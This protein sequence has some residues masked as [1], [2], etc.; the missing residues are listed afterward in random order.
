[1]T[2]EWLGPGLQAVA[3]V[4]TLVAAIAA[5][6]AAATANRLVKDEAKRRRLAAIQ[7]IHATL[8]RLG[9]SMFRSS[10]WERGLFELRSLLIQTDVSLPAAAA[11][12]DVARDT[13]GVTEFEHLALAAIREVELFMAGESGRKPTVRQETT[14]PPS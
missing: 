1:M 11:V 8:A 12:A 2:P 13:V 6:R 3:A 4:G 14:P 7:S 9:S 5:W 10:E